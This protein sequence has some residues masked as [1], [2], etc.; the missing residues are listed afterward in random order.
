MTNLSPSVI[1]QYHVDVNQNFMEDRWCHQKKSPTKC[2]RTKVKWMCVFL[3]LFPDVT[4]RSILDHT[5]PMVI[6]N[7]GRNKSTQ[8]TLNTI[9][10]CGGLSKASGKEHVEVEVARGSIR[11]FTTLLDIMNGKIKEKIGYTLCFG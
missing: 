4:L 10:S 5:P 8:L 3:S 9:F 11:P 1:C 2:L 6:S 7:H